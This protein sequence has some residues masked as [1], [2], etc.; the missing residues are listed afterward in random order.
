M[1]PIPRTNLLMSQI[2]DSA[3]RLRAHHRQRQ[4][5]ALLTMHHHDA[6]FIERVL[7]GPQQRRALSRP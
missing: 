1:F 2:V 7:S 3:I 5:E 6:S 4:A